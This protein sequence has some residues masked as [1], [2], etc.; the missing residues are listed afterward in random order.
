MSETFFWDD[1]STRRF[2]QI[3]ES[4]SDRI[5]LLLGSHTHFVDFRINLPNPKS[6][7][8]KTTKIVMLATASISPVNLNNPGI[9][10]M[11]IDNNE[12]KDVKFVFLELFMFPQNDS[13]AT[14]NT[15]DL[16]EEYGIS[17]IT[18]KSIQT[19]IEDLEKNSVK[20]HRYIA[21]K[22]GFRGLTELV[23]AGRF[24]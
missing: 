11:K 2:T 12:V 10:L 14:F 20:F 5:L 15:L 19:F 8:E 18:P 3:V 22:I 1:E 23:G 17:T 13:D 4:Y 9:T 16:N 21:H 24:L 6:T 7:V